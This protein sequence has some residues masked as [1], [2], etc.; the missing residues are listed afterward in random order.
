M[1]VLLP[2]SSAALTARFTGPYIVYK[3]IVETTY[4][5]STPDHRCTK[6]VAIFIC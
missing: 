6:R 2:V 4:V 5:I 1:L 3:R